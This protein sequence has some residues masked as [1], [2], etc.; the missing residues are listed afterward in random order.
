MTK[1]SPLFLRLALGVS[2]LSAVA[3]RFGFWGLPGSPS[4]S[5]GNWQN[6]L[7]Y[8]NAVNSFVPH[9]LAEVLAV[10][11]TGLEILLGWLLILGYRVRL[12]ALVSGILLLSFALAMTISFGFKPSLYYSVWTGAAAAF[13]LSTATSNMYS[14]DQIISKK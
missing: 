2:F 11:A 14:I 1:L 12:A 5:W 13:L 10:A 8:S 9:Q 3:D 4:V 7:S 6:F